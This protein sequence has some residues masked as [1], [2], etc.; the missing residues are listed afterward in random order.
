MPWDTK[1]RV[2]GR[3]RKKLSYVY[4]VRGQLSINAGVVIAQN[5]TKTKEMVQAWIDCP[6]NI[7]GCDRYRHGWPA[8]QGA[9]ASFVRYLYNDTDIVTIDCN[10]AN[11]YP[12]QG[13]DC[14]G[15][16]LRHFTTDKSRVKANV[17]ETLLQA[18]SE[19][20]ARQLTDVQQSSA[21]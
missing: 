14:E 6:D 18:L 15:R 4:D 13:M 16:Y 20:F 2:Q 10:D 9:F 5:L 1:Y 19:V 3:R 21:Q 8:E 12:E 7:P 17:A 11:G